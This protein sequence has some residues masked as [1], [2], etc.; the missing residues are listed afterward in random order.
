MTSDKTWPVSQIIQREIDQKRVE[1]IADQYIL[2]NR[3]VKY[4]P[5]IVV[6]IL[7]KNA[8]TGSIADTYKI[9]ENDNLD[10][11]KLEKINEKW[12]IKDNF[13]ILKKAQNESEVENLFLLNVFPELGYRLLVWDKK[14]YYCVVIDGQHRFESLKHSLK[15]ERST[16]DYRQD[17]VFIDVSSKAI[18]SR[19]TPVKAVRNIFIDI[20]NNATPVT[21]A[22]KYVMDDKDLASLFVQSLVNDDPLAGSEQG[23]FIQPQLVDWHA[24]NLKHELPHLTGILALYQLMSDVVI[25]NNLV[26][27]DD[28]RNEG[29]VKRWVTKLNTKFLIDEKIRERKEYSNIKTLEDSLKKFQND[30]G[31]EDPEEEEKESYLFE[32]DYNILK[33]AQKTFVECYCR[34]IVK[35]FYSLAPYSVLVK[36][37]K[38]KN[39]FD[40]DSNINRVVITS[41]KKMDKVKKELFS[42]LKGELNNQLEGEYYLIFTVLGQ[43]TLFELFFKEIDRN[44]GNQIKEEHIL[45][46]TDNFLREYN[47]LFDVLKFAPEYKIF[48][49]HPIKNSVVTKDIIDETVAGDYGLHTSSF[50]EDVIYRG[51]T[52]IYNSQGIN[53]M[54]AVFE[55]MID[56][57]N[58]N[59][60]TSDP[61][62]IQLPETLDIPLAKPRIKKAIMKEYSYSDTR[63]VK[64]A[65]DILV[66]KKMFLDRYLTECLEGYLKSKPA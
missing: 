5:P 26:S 18:K 44:V 55:Y 19:I 34:S 33:I 12:L 46:I 60:N 37:L 7:P 1:N 43:K 30:N 47:Q 23:K 53:S 59:E 16:A 66:A 8:E 27:I 42:N 48:G 25:K 36:L 3:N 41:G 57:L 10:E 21:Q 13:E 6:V 15:K 61:S 40:R 52:I 51:S 49:K 58:I 9:A 14:Q 31:D 50:W 28:L 38:S 2:A 39:V 29:K 56:V 54:R 24:D 32:Y 45:S 35:Y 22:R 11:I 63:S 62:Q 20:N 64:I 17:I 65:N 4:F